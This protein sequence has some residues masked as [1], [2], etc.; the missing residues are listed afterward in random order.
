M[1]FSFKTKRRWVVASVVVVTMASCAWILGGLTWYAQHFARRALVQRDYQRAWDWAQTARRFDA[2][3]S[4]TEFLQARIERK[5]G[6]LAD[7]M[8][9]LN[10]A[11]TLGGDRQRARREA[12]LAQAQSG[13][14]EDILVELDR[15][16]VDHSEDGVDICEAY[17]NGLLINGQLDNAEAVIQQWA[18]AFPKDPQPDHM[19]GRIAEFRRQ[20]SL[21]E[22]HYRAAMGKEPRHLPSAYG[23]G[24]THLEGN[25][26]SEALTE[27][28]KCLALPVR[29]PAQLGMARALAGLGREQEAL[30]LLR[31]AART[32]RNDWLD[33]CRQLGEPTEFDNLSFELGNLEAK[34]GRH[35]EAIRWLQ[36]AVDYNP[37]H[38]QARYQLA[39]SL[40]AAGR[41]EEAKPHF[42][43]YAD[44]DAKLRE[45]DRLH[46]IV[47]RNSEDHAARIRLGEL[48]L[49]TESEA[50]GL[51]WLRGVLAEEPQN[52]AAH[53]TLADWFERAAHTRPEY[54][55]LA[56]YHRAR[57]SS[58]PESLPLQ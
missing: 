28:Q 43:W 55:G 46:D 9:H 54:Q 23:L 3:N 24:R 48:Y 11:G 32:P 34:A 2:Q 35:R 18:I 31:T 53:T 6:H 37:R 38:K 50:A 29:G 56:K 52:G 5:R 39:L 26:W 8:Q 13:D 47:A 42:Q 20:S 21:A 58:A 33:T 25:R 45:R 27:F 19:Q 4:E 41:A 57:A 51:F 40:Q 12:V 44:L 16:L 49:E 14:L 10:R 36:Y 7:A 17:V 30:D 15:M 22:G 1:K